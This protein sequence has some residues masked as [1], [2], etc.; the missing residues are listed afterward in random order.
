MS[1]RS[2]HQL[3]GTSEGPI[4]PEIK[5]LQTQLRA[6]K[7]LQPC[8]SDFWEQ[9]SDFWLIMLSNSNI[10]IYNVHSSKET[11]ELYIR[12]RNERPTRTVLVLCKNVNTLFIIRY[13]FSINK[14]FDI[15]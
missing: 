12:P 7:T 4:E 13:Q 3:H 11:L 5:D 6:E 9:I 1:V 8:L 2:H 14:Q 15:E 10:L